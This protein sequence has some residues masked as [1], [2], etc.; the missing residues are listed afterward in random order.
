[1]GLA[2]TVGLP[3]ARAQSF[4]AMAMLLIR[5]GERDSAERHLNR[6]MG[7]AVRMGS[8]SIRFV[9]GLARARLALAGGKKKAALAALARALAA[10]RERGYVNFSWW[11]PDFMAELCAV[12]LAHGV[13]QD[14]VRGLIRR[15]ELAP[16]ADAPDN[17]PWPVRIFVLGGLRLEVGGE[18]VRFGGK[19]P[20]RPLQ[21]LSFLA[22]HGRDGVGEEVVSDTL[23]PDADG[24]A[25]HKS[26]EVTVTRLRKLLGR[27]EAVVFRGGRLGINRDICRLDAALFEA[28]L[29]KVEAG[30]NSA[31]LETALAL[32]QGP[33]LD[34]EDAPWAIAARERLQDKFVRATCQAADI[35]RKSGKNAAAESLYRRGIDAAATAPAL[36][37]ELI[38]FY[39]ATGRAGLAD[40]TARRAAA[41]LR[42]A[43]EPLPPGLAA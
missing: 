8:A 38:A 23:W 32:Y 40:S 24:D 4:L 41:A 28:R 31:G 14:Y 43:G 29:D 10:G 39:R 33:F 30:E 2:E 20:K 36:Y 12:A 11:H 16:P 1:M 17:W 9:C 15:R 5:R 27:R 26:I 3:Y 21:L 42:A 22:A 19:V 18:E 6:A 13:E 25:A 37:L 7:I 34:G 35:L